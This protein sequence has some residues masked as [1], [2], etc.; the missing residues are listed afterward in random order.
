MGYSDFDV[1]DI[2][3]YEEILESLNSDESFEADDFWPPSD[4]V[5]ES[6]AAFASSIIA[7]VLPNFSI[8]L[9]L[10]LAWRICL[11][12]YR[13]LSRSIP[14]SGPGKSSLLS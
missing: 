8:S 9:A 11:L 2:A 10:C 14:K 3:G 12:L 4:H 13:R 1:T 6:F 5:G 7:Q